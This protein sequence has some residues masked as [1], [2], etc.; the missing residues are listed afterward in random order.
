MAN[1]SPLVPFKILSVLLYG[2]HSWLRREGTTVYARSGP[3]NR[4]LK[5]RP[6]SLWGMLDWLQGIGLVT[7]WSRPEP[8]YVLVEVRLPPSETGAGTIPDAIKGPKSGRRSLLHTEQGN[9]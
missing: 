4:I 9:I 2:T 5:N 7:R 6:V 8:G 1:K 3:L